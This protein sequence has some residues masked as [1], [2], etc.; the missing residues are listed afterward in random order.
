MKNIGK[1]RNSVSMTLLVVLIHSIYSSVSVQAG[2]ENSFQEWLKK[3]RQQMEVWQKGER[4]IAKQATPAR[5]TET[6]SPDSRNQGFSTLPPTLA[7]VGMR[8]S[9]LPRLNT[10]AADTVFSLTQS[11]DTMQI[12]TNSGGIIW[13]P[14]SGDLGTAAV[15]ITAESSTATNTQSF[16]I[17]I[18]RF[19]SAASGIISTN[20]GTVSGG[21]CSLTA[22]GGTLNRD[23]NISL[24]TIE[25]MPAADAIPGIHTIGAM[26]AIQIL[27]TDGGVLKSSDL[28]DLQ[29][30]LSFDPAV[31][32]E[33]IK[34]DQVKLFGFDP[35]HMERAHILNAETKS[36][37]RVLLGVDGLVCVTIALVLAPPVIVAASEVAELYNQNV[38]YTEVYNDGYV[39]VFY[40]DSIIADC[41]D[42]RAYGAAIAKSINRARGDD[43]NLGCSMPSSV[44]VMVTPPAGCES[45]SYLSFSELIY[46]SPNL[47]GYKLSTSPAHEFFHAVQDEYYVMG[48]AGILTQGSATSDVY[49]WTEACAVWFASH[50]FPD[51]ADKEIEF[52]LTTGY[53]RYPLNSTVQKAA[54]SKGS[55]VQ[56]A[57]AA[58]QKKNFVRDVMNASSGT[59]GV[60]SSIN[61]ILPLD[62]H[63]KKYV[64]WALNK[65]GDKSSAGDGIILEKM[66]PESSFWIKPSIDSMA[67]RRSVNIA[68]LG[69]E[70][71]VVQEMFEDASEG[72]PYV[73]YIHKIEANSSLN[74]SPGKVIDVEFVRT[75]HENHDT[76]YV[77]L[78]PNDNTEPMYG[79][80]FAADSGYIRLP[81]IGKNATDI[82]NAAWLVYTDTSDSDSSH[83]KWNIQVRDL[84]P[85]AG[86]WVQGFSVSSLDYKVIQLPNPAKN[87]KAAHG[88]RLSEVK[89]NGHSYPDY[90]QFES[91][92]TQWLR[93]ELAKEKENEDSSTVTESIFSGISVG[94]MLYVIPGFKMLYD[95]MPFA[96]AAEMIDENHYL[97]IL[98]GMTQEQLQELKTNKNAPPLQMY[99]GTT[100]SGT[101]NVYD[102]DDDGEMILK[103]NIE[104]TDNRDAIEYTLSLIGTGLSLEDKTKNAIHNLEIHAGGILNYQNLR[105][106]ETAADQKYTDILKKIFMQKL[107]K[108]KKQTD[109]ILKPIVD[110]FSEKQLQ[111]AFK[112]HSLRLFR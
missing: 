95:G 64:N 16:T 18:T 68:P 102:E 43:Y 82:Y 5:R 47:S 85:F 35:L 104:L 56:Y 36:A 69:S 101:W 13:F 67:T 46:I 19:V 22:P 78:K 55:F 45:G 108:E 61:K 50:V 57:V 87:D 86:P 6:A 66:L 90:S 80:E 103:W 73:A 106:G 74:G 84:D 72:Y 25:D 89:I 4:S 23:I 40:D 51:V 62:T 15:E 7:V 53:L 32:P 97:P 12:S 28:K 96:M 44:E 42:P 93:D 1:L 77:L 111:G 9:Y 41:R 79:I 65:Y 59:A 29:L 33:G 83:Y 17:N 107:E 27:A 38:N 2:A 31:L 110:G 30:S 94:I 58:A 75:G 63:Y 54:Y 98:P 21:N 26:K 92:A 71:N 24:N 48:Q 112:N 60:I 49:W 76:P 91:W 99:N 70:S 20:G 37:D 100:L 52:A 11:P 39:Q 14:K 8:Y 109:A 34:P 81:R 10:K 88:I 105:H 3:D